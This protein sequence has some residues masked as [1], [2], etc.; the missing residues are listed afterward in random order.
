M[1]LLVRKACVFLYSERSSDKPDEEVFDPLLVFVPVFSAT[2]QA[3]KRVASNPSDKAMR[4]VS[5]TGNNSRRASN[6][7]EGER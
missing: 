2:L 1:I 6:F 4:I 3:A 7:R 5:R